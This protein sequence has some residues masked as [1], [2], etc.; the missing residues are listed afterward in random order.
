MIHAALYGIQN[1]LELP[2]ASDLNLYKADTKVLAGFKRL[3][4]SLKEA[5]DVASNSAFVAQCLPQAI[6]DIYCR[7]SKSV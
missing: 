6:L 2:E 5:R 3:P 7:T 4:S 1:H